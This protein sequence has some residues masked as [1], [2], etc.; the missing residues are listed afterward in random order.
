MRALELPRANLFIADD[1]GLGKTIEAG[2]ILQE[3]LLR[4]RVEQASSSSPRLG[5]ASSGSDEMQSSASASFEIYDRDF[6]ARLPPGARL[7]RQPLDHPHPLHHLVPDPAPPRVPRPAASRDLARGRARKSLLI[8]DEAHTAAP[9]S[10]A[11]TPST[12][13]SPAPS[14]SSPRASST[15]SSSPPR[16]TTATPTPSRPCSRSSTRSAS[17]AASR[18]RR[19]PPSTRSW[20]AASS[21]T[22]APSAAGSF[23]PRGRAQPRHATVAG[24]ATTQTATAPE[25]DAPERRAPRALALLAEYTALVRPAKGR[26]R[27]VFINLQKRLLSRRGLRRTL[28]LHAAAV[29]ARAGAAP[30]TPRA[31]TTTTT[32]T[33]TTT[34]ARSSTAPPTPPALRVARPDATARDLLDPMLALAPAT[35]T[36][37]TASCWPCSRGCA[38]P[39]RPRADPRAAREGPRLERPPRP[40]LHRV[41]RHQ[42]L[43]RRTSS[44]PPSRP[45]DQADARIDAVSTAAWATTQR[46]EVQRPST[47]T[48]PSTRCASSSPPT[49]PARASTSRATAPTCSTS[50][51][52]GTPPA[53]SSATAASTARCSPPPV[54]RCHYFVYP[55]APRTRARARWSRR[56]R[57]SSELGSLS[58]VVLDRLD[59]R[60][61]RGI[62]DRDEDLWDWRKR[63]PCRWCFDPPARASPRTSPTS[64]SRTR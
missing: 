34:P 46:E 42:A 24:V 55:S 62:D 9:A 14:A 4:Q 41:R 15:A 38:P 3:L 28:Q 31:A 30:P 5:H 57:A 25:L 23:P 2:L 7:R 6:V 63:P 37:P 53:W 64:T 39:V 8:L 12:R 58:A 50:T 11:A 10:G 52:P 43:P 59:R 51:S 60:P 26:G 40:H 47:P 54:V 16:R 22:C 48:P 18:R 20:S 56:S 32:T 36:R 13:A 33:S 21:A 27:L 44:P 1:V 17:P 61:R 45:T 35:A 19:P 49:P 29:T